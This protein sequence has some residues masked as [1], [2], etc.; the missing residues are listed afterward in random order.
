MQTI[1]AGSPMQVVAVDITGPLPESEAGNRYI[2]VVGDYFTKWMEAYAIPDQEATTVATKLVDEFYCRFG[3]PEQLHSDQGRQFES[4]LIQQICS[5]L[6]I[7]KSRTTAYHPQCDGLVERFNRTLKHMLATSLK[8]HPFDWEDRLRKVCMAYNTS[9]HAS[10]GYTPFYLLYGREARLP[11]DL[12]YGTKRPSPQSVHEYASHL[13]QS[14]KDAYSAVRQQ[15]NQAHARQKQYYDRKVHGEPYKKGDLVWLHNPT[16]PPGQS[17]KL[18]HPWTGPYRIVERLSEVDY[19]IQEL[20]GKKTP[21]VVHFDRL[22]RCHPDTRFPDQ[23]TSDDTPQDQPENL[24][25]YSHFDIELIEP[26][27][28]E[29]APLRRSTRNRQQPNRYEPMILH[30]V[31]FGTNS[32]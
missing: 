7:S 31:E 11:I 12:M 20:F 17:A 24:T 8:D 18:M 28:V 22:K 16:V 32:S 3:P 2:L 26:D 14:L 9:V 19:R 29:S 4:K 1:Q 27:A 23:D 21:S 13:K 25:L 15:L 30:Q 5:I 10:S 6:K